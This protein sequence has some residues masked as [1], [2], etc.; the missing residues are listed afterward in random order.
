MSTA[1]RRSG[2]PWVTTRCAARSRDTLTDYGQHLREDSAASAYREVMPQLHRLGWI[3]FL[4]CAV[5]YTVA[6]LR[7]GDA[8]IVIGSIT[9][10]VACVLF[11]VDPPETGD[12]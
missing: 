2:T 10:G 6:G 4:V 5:L 8:L 12:P 9:F 7:D 11:L 3:L 1:L